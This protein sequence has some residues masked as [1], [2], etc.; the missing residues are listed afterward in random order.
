MPTPPTRALLMKDVVCCVIF[1]FAR[2]KFIF[3]CL[4]QLY[5]NVL[6]L[7]PL[8]LQQ[9]YQYL[10]VD[11]DPLH[12]CEHVMPILEGLKEQEQ[13]TQYVKPLESIILV[14]LIKQ[15]KGQHTL[16]LFL[17]LT[18]DVCILRLS[19]ITMVMMTILIT[20]K[21]MSLEYNC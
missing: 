18:S 3:Y 17:L 6:Q 12:L 1:F 14:R 7:L 19:E 2:E 20:H 8:E 21:L 13:C 16:A 15:V 11:F 10:E 4:Y 9:L 5:Y